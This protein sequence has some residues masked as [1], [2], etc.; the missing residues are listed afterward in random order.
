MYSIVYNA[1]Y[2]IDGKHSRN[3][4]ACYH[5]CLIGNKVLSQF[6]KKAPTAE[7]SA[8]A[9]VRQAKAIAMAIL[10]LPQRPNIEC[11]ICSSR[12]G[13]ETCLLSG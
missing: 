11:E 5:S 3:K 4:R 9:V 6:F 1:V 12:A 2:T 10:M 13:L 8:I 7:V